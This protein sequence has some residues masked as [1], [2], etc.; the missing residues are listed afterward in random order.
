MNSMLL[1]SFLWIKECFDNAL[2]NCCTLVRLSSRTPQASQGICLRKSWKQGR[3]RGFG[4]RDW[5]L[6]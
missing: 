4:A 6:E 1:P 2:L 5:I 3:F